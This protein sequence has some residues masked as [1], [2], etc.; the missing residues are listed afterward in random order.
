MLLGY[1]NIFIACDFGACFLMSVVIRALERNSRH[2][3]S[4]EKACFPINKS[5]FQSEDALEIGSNPIVFI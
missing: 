2:L 5:G 3:G 4:S 1:I